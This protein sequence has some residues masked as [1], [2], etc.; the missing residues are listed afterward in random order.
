MKKAFT[1]IELLS[2]VAIIG[3][4]AGILFVSIGQMPLKKARDA[5]RLNDMKAMQGA[6]AR[7]A[8]DNNG[9]YP[10]NRTP[11]CGYPDTN[12]DFLKELVDGGYLPQ[13]PQGP[14]GGGYWYYDYGGG[15]SIGAILVTTL[16][17]DPPSTTGRPESCRPWASGANWCDQSSNTYYCL[18]SPH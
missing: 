3:I 8:L 11:C 16:E 9:N 12:A 2:V 6:L 1:L 17:S 5:K 18:C 7:Y 4:L 14:P 10:I 15:N 13:K